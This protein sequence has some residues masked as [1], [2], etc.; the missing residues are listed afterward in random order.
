M[1]L[2]LDKVCSTSHCVSCGVRIANLC[3]TVGKILLDIL[4][5]LKTAS[6]D[7]ERKVLDDWKALLSQYTVVYDVAHATGMA[8]MEHMFLTLKGRS[9]RNGASF[10]SSVPLY[11]ATDLKPMQE[12]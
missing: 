9:L 2:Q 11:G 10:T 3:Q 7:T 6:S 12:S 8:D 1:N 5:L 4:D